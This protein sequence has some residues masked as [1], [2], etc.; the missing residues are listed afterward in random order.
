MHPRTFHAHVKGS[1][2]VR[3]EGQLPDSPLRRK[4]RRRNGF[5][6]VRGLRL[7]TRSLKLLRYRRARRVG[8]HSATDIARERPTVQGAR[9]PIRYST[10]EVCPAVSMVP[11]P[12]TAA[13]SPVIPTS[14]SRHHSIADIASEL[15][16][17]P[18]ARE[19]GSSALACF[20]RFLEWREVPG[21]EVI[22]R[23][24]DRP[25]FLCL[26]LDGVVEIS[27]ETSGSETR[28]LARFTA[29]K[30]FGEVSLIDGEPRSATAHALEPSRILV[31]TE[32]RFDELAVQY[33]RLA[34]Q[35]MRVLARTLSARLRAT[36]GRL[37]DLL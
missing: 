12:R 6:S 34:L 24:G 10:P 37:V 19:V 21:G 4:R 30:M 16:Y 8:R 26:L 29:G 7:G 13:R 36:S 18:W 2:S 33:P 22:F 32:E 1:A 14:S 27:K 35:V 23:Q 17:T 20:A 11:P 3:F 25:R 5:M 28:T 15:E 31:L 9:G